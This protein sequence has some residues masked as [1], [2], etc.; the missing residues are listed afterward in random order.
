MSS[1]LLNDLKVKFDAVLDDLAPDVSGQRVLQVLVLVW[2]Q[3][4]HALHELISQSGT[5]SELGAL[6]NTKANTTKA[7]QCEQ[8]KGDKAHDARDRHAVLR[9]RHA[10]LL[11]S[12]VYL[13]TAGG[14]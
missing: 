7:K 2:G 14:G 6:K 1:S 8:E 5:L 11:Y 4:L 13:G 9:V 3:D 10:P 12:T